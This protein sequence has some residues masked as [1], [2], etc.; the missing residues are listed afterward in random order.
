MLQYVKGTSDFGVLYG[1]AKGPKLIRYIDSDWVGSVDDRKS[2]LGYVF[3][4]GTSAVTWTNEKQQ[5]VALSSIED[6]YR[7][8]IKA[9]CEAVWLRRVLSDMQMS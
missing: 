1:R 8:T 6:E 3:S 7:G 5:A 4:L 9:T 2:T